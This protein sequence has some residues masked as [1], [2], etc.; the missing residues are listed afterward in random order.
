MSLTKELRSPASSITAYLDARL[1][2]V[3]TVERVCTQRLAATSQVKASPCSDW[4]HLGTAFEVSIGLD[5]AESV[6]YEDL[7]LRRP[8]DEN[9]RLLRLAGFT[10]LNMPWGTD[11]AVSRSGRESLSNEGVRE[12]LGWC[13]DLIVYD[14]L[15][16]HD[17]NLVLKI[18]QQDRASEP[19]G[20]F[21]PTPDGSHLALWQT[22]QA[23]GRQQ[24]TRLGS[25]VTVAPSLLS[26]FAVPDIILGTTL[27][28]IKLVNEPG[29]Q[30]RQWLRQLL[31]YVLADTDDR[32][33][34]R[35]VGIFVGW[36]MT[37]LDW[38]LAEV[39]DITDDTELADARREFS[40][41][42]SHVMEEIRIRKK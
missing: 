18:I 17:P 6:P 19:N 22:Y 29:P 14:A 4:A 37:L 24:L 2:N 16:K 35:R 20:R 30:I 10:S 36:H 42:C 41:L 32:H 28:D 40:A 7:L 23:R 33:Q 27:V 26:G 25:P 5:L 15:R 8:A 31:G 39:T 3:D 38:K 11:E 12:Y 21:I 13:W 9:D 1:C 34:M